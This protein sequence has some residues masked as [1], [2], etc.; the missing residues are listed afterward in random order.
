[1]ESKPLKKS[2]IINRRG[3]RNDVGVPIESN[4]V[5]PITYS[6][7]P[8]WRLAKKL[9]PDYVKE[10]LKEKLN[11]DYINNKYA[12]LV[13]VH[14]VDYNTLSN[15]WQHRLSEV[16]YQLDNTTYQIVLNKQAK[17]LNL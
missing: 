13:P 10:T 2:D 3:L 14:D 9:D 17:N 7:T 15:E 12:V 6:D 8:G 16:W 5:Y 1:M 11:V 4:L